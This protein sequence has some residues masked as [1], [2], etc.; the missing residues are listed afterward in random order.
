MSL[1]GAASV[2]VTKDQPRPLSPAWAETH[3]WLARFESTIYHGLRCGK[4]V[5]DHARALLAS[6]PTDSPFAAHPEFALVAAVCAA[7]RINGVC[8]CPKADRGEAPWCADQ[9]PRVSS[10]TRIP[11]PLFTPLGD[12]LLRR[13][14]GT[15]NVPA[16]RAKLREYLPSK[17]P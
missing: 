11:E 10:L 7:R 2:V 6:L 15:D 14:F 4:R 3:N 17:L 5:L 16:I 1:S 9:C 8:I 12:E 13:A